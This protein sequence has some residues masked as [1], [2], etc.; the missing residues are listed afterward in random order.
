MVTCKI[1]VV[2]LWVPA[3]LMLS[4]CA[5]N[6]SGDPVNPQNVSHELANSQQTVPVRPAQAASPSNRRIVG[7]VDTTIRQHPWQVALQVRDGT[8]WLLC[9]GSLVT[10]RRVVTAAHC[11][12]RQTRPSE[13]KLKAGT[14]YYMT[15]GTWTDVER[16]VLHDNYDAKTHENDIALIKVGASTSGR[17]IRLAIATE[18]LREMQ[19]LEVTGWGAMSEGGP[20]SPKLQKVRV[21]FV[22]NATCNKPGAYHSHITPGMICAGLRDGGID[23]CQGDS[24]GPLVKRTESGPVLV[25]VVSFGEGCA[26]KLKYGVYTRVSYYRGWI[27]RIAGADPI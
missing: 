27:E 23:A 10:E 3:S 26:R 18:P 7:G 14:T 25:G 24:G 16:I 11:F 6:W 1:S 17:P 9:G 13:V 15:E 5:V 2:R 21:P 8:G 20:A 4:S 22:S 19:W 12:S